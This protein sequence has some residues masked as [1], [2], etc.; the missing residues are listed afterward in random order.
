MWQKL[1]QNSNLFSRVYTALKTTFICKI[2]LS[3]YCF[4]GVWFFLLYKNKVLGILLQ[5]AISLATWD[6]KENC[7]AVPGWLSHFGT[8]PI[9][10]PLKAPENLSKNLLFSGV[11]GRKKWQHWQEMSYRKNETNICIRKTKTLKK[12]TVNCLN[13]LCSIFRWQIWRCKVFRKFF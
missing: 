4:S 12:V 9:L 6:R 3:P 5:T 1:W 13:H 10:W 7:H 8:V 2:F 11:S